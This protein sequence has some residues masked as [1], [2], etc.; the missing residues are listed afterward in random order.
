VFL[1]VSK[2]NKKVRQ[3]SAFPITCVCVCTKMDERKGE[4]HRCVDEE[5]RRI[6]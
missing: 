6:T 2:R 5:K 1:L 4:N 3:L